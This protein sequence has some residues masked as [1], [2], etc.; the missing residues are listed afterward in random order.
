M[1][2]EDYKIQASY[3][4]GSHGNNMLN[5]RAHTVEELAALCDETTD[6][7]QAEDFL[8]NL[9]D[10]LSIS[11]TASQAAQ[12]VQAAIPGSIVVPSCQ[13]GPMKDL[14]AKNYRHRWYCAAPKGTQ[15][16]QARD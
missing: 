7:L 11:A 3:K 5:V 9:S 13:H 14:S 6:R 10:A 2:N 15:Q 4:F 8:T 1:S 16:C 12:N